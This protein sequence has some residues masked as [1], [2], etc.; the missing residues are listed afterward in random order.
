MIHVQS[1]TFNPFQENTYIV[2]NGSQALLIDPGCYTEKEEDQLSAYLHSNGLTL[3]HCINTHAHLDHIFGNAW[4]FR[5]YGLKPWLH[6]ADLFLLQGA[7]NTAK[8]YGLSFEESPEPE[9]FMEEGDT[10][11]LGTEILR[12]LYVPGHAPGHIALYSETQGFVIA[13]DVL[14]KRSI[15][16]TDLPGG[17]MDILLD[18]IRTKLLP[19]PADT[20]V[21]CGHGPTTTIGEEIR[22]NPFLV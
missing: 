16:R 3:T 21:Y 1:F 9:Q 6:R 11:T 19:L 13:G 5:T 2:H 18:S 7:P 4:T 12:V 10:F 15:G 17:D 22:M 14:F 8:I 20:L